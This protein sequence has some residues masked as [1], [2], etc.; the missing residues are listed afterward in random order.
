MAFLFTAN[1][2]RALVHTRLVIG[3]NVSGNGFVTK[4]DV[5][6]IISILIQFLI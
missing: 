1:R 3:V 5:F 2:I 6:R 4:V